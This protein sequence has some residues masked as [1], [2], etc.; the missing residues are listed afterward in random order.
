MRWHPGISPLFASEEAVTLVLGTIAHESDFGSHTVQMGGGPAL[1]IAQIE[2]STFVWL[3]D[4]YAEKFPRHILK[5]RFSRDL[6]TDNELSILVCRLR[7]L[8]VKEP[9]PQTKDE[10]AAYYKKYYN[11]AAGKAE[12]ADFLKALKRAAEWPTPMTESEQV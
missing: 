12:P 5:D 2:P 9:L 4:K 6:R 8:V 1:G 3:Q 10:M 11:T 7:Y